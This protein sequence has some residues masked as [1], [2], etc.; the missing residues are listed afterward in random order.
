MRYFEI[1]WILTIFGI[2]AGFYGGSRA[3]IG[4]PLLPPITVP[5]VLTKLKE[6]T[7]D[8]DSSF[9]RV[10]YTTLLKGTGLEGTRGEDEDPNLYI[11]QGKGVLVAYTDKGEKGHRQ[12]QVAVALEETRGVLA[13]YFDRATLKRVVID[14]VEFGDELIPLNLR[15]GLGSVLRLVRLIVRDHS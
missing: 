3:T 12:E 1:L 4:D 9:K 7:E 11:F 14:G 2:L 15:P 10:H 6:V 13:V 8:K 5:L